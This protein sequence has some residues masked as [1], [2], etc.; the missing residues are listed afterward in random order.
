MREVRVEGG[1]G[2]R[3]VR[4][5]VWEAVTRRLVGEG[6]GLV[7]FSLDGKGLGLG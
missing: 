4:W 5:R 3:A 1:R 6:G 7:W 2:G